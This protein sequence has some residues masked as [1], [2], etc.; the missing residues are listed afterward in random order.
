MAGIPA[1]ALLASDD[2]RIVSY[3]PSAT[4][5]KYLRDQPRLDRHSGLL[6]LGDPVYDRG[7]QGGGEDFEPLP[8]TQYE[9]EA[10]AR[11]FKAD[12]RPSR[13]LLGTDASEPEFDRLAASGELGRFG[14]IHL[15]SMA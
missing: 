12:D 3:A 6:A 5:F 14:F 8:G 9:V 1:E 11:L 7:S 13:A 2:N 10:L 4:V 15:A